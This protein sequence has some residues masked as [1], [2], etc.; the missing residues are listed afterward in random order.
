LVFARTRAS[1]ELVVRYISD[2]SPELGPLTRGYRGGYTATERRAIEADLRE[3]RARCIVAT[4]ALELGIDIGALDAVIMAGYPGTV[5]ST[6]QQAGRVGRRAGHSVAVL[7]AAATPLD[8]FVVRHPEFVMS[9][10]HEHARIDPDNLLILL[11][12]VR[13]AAFELPFHA[14]EAAAPFGGPEEVGFP[15]PERVGGNPA[16]GRPPAPALSELLAVLESQGV[17]QRVDGTW[18]WLADAY[19]AEGVGLRSSGGDAVTV[20]RRDGPGDDVLGTVDRPTAPMMVHPGAVYMHGG[21]TF[22]VE[23]L[24]WD[25]GRAY[26]SPTDGA[27]YTR[28]SATTTIA[29]LREDAD[30]PVPG[31]RAFCGELEIRTRATAYRKI[32]FRTHETVGWGT[33]DLPEQSYVAGGYWFTLDAPTVARLAQSGDM[34]IDVTGDRGPTWARARDAARVRDGYRCRRCGAP[35]RPE[36]Q[37]DVHHLAPYSTFRE[38]AGYVRHERANALDNLVTLCRPC[39]GAV[40]RETGMQG[41]LVGLGYALSHVACLYL[42]CDPHDLRVTAQV[43]APWTGKPTVAIYESATA[44]VGFGTALFGLHE[45]LLRTVQALIGSCPCTEGCPSCTGVPDETG[46]NAKARTLAIL[47]LLT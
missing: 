21:A 28:A 12:H 14:D 36:R 9:G 40:E 13:C 20:I 2:A 27:L 3:G 7:V 41:T 45:E 34:W 42:M 37:H 30:R 47:E 31:A 26:V 33:I 39:H 29:P 23:S 19:P 35:E 44:G 17:V 15:A 43:N 1:T 46:P 25:G 18:Y 24:D 16:G 38:A 6:W 8:Q 10:A 11:N 4:N 32:R 22:I 5:A